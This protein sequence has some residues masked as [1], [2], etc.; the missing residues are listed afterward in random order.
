M[1]HEPKNTSWSSKSRVG[2]ISRFTLIELLVVIAIIAILASMLLP[3]LGK[4][5]DKAKTIYCLANL[6]QIGLGLN[7]YS[8]DNGEYLP[9]PAYKPATNS[10]RWADSIA[11]YVNYKPD[12]FECP[13]RTDNRTRMRKEANHH[14]YGVGSYGINAHMHC[15][16]PLRTPTGTD[17]WYSINF[18]TD[19][20]FEHLKASLVKSPSNLIIVGDSNLA[21]SSMG[22]S[23]FL[24]AFSKPGDLCYTWY[25]SISD[26]HHRKANLLYFDG[27]ANTREPYTLD[28]QNFGTSVNKYLSAS[29]K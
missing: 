17:A 7:G 26:R 21:T 2:L 1:E 27:H 3:A 9:N 4:A 25:G 22:N 15:R 28:W 29:Q 10:A 20:I 18:K 6:K 11:K 13:K 8:G 12:V 5:R 24:I 19:G 23:M 16:A 14:F